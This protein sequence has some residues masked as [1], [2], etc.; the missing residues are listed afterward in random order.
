MK[1]GGKLVAVGRVLRC[2]KDYTIYVGCGEHTTCKA[3]NVATVKGV[4]KTGVTLYGE[5]CAKTI[6]VPLADLQ[7]HYVVEEV[8]AD[9]QKA[10]IHSAEGNVLTV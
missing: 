4:S 5:R 7:E 10:V 3:G 8:T 9:N 2:I 6:V 1:L